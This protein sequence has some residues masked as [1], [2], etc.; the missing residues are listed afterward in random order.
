MKMT[1]DKALEQFHK[2]LFMNTGKYDSTKILIEKK[3]MPDLKN[4]IELCDSTYDA[5]MNN[6]VKEWIIVG[7]G[8]SAGM[9]LAISLI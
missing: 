4:V 5:K 3:C 6:I 7:I 8:I 1:C 2:C 9:G